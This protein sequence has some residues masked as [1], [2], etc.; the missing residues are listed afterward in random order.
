MVVKKSVTEST[1]SLGVAVMVTGLLLAV[2]GFLMTMDKG[3][4]Y[5]LIGLGMLLVILGYVLLP[6]DGGKAARHTAAAGIEAGKRPPPP[7]WAGLTVATPAAKSCHAV[8]SDPPRAAIGH[9]VMAERSR[10]A[11]T[12][13]QRRIRRRMS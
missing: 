7:L 10:A 4:P 11:A 3:V 1:E 13:C 8:I 6:H 12:G 5:R 2:F 9:A